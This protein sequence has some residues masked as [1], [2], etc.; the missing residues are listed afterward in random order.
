[1][2]T[3]A[4]SLLAFPEQPTLETPMIKQGPIATAK[5]LGREVREVM[6]RTTAAVAGD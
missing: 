2:S 1:M 6:M 5:R 4:A 3:L